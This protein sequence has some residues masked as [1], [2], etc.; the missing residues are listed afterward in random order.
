MQLA[1]FYILMSSFCVDFDGCMYGLKSKYARVWSLQSEIC[2]E[3]ASISSS[4]GELFG[5]VRGGCHRRAPC[6]VENALYF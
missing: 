6:N 3:M 5:K 2:G 4:I 1:F